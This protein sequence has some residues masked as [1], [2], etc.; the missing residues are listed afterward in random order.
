MQNNNVDILSELDNS[1]DDKNLNIE[2]IISESLDNKEELDIF[3]I[4]EE[5]KKYETIE[6]FY[7]VK[8]VEKRNS[9]V[10]WIIF[11]WKYALT[12]SLIFAVL[13]VTTN[14]SAY[15]NVAKSYVFAWE[16]KSTQQKLVTSV[17]AANIKDKYSEVVK[18]EIEQ[19]EKEA[20]KL[21]IKKMIKEQD[22]KNIDLNIE[23]TPYEN[24][25]II[26]KIWKNIPLLDIKNRSVKWEEELHDIFMKELKKEIIR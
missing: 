8:K 5:E 25:V 11:M 23:I 21:S 6:Y 16:M 20:E 9:L 7:S 13:L 18:E 1:F 24:R 12:T 19:E 2:A 10:S 3:S 4:I 15:I 22:K 17:E 26:P 14:Y